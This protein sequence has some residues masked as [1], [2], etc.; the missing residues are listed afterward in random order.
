MFYVCLSII[1]L[2]ILSDLCLSIDSETFLLLHCVCPNEE[3]NLYWMIR[4]W[5]KRIKEGTL[6]NQEKIWSSFTKKFITICILKR[7]LTILCQYRPSYFVETLNVSFSERKKFETRTICL[8]ISQAKFKGNKIKKLPISEKRHQ[9][10][11]E[12]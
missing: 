8:W 11:G 2:L 10:D 12:H 1:R 7:S 5:Q 9:K 3:D 4:R 6:K